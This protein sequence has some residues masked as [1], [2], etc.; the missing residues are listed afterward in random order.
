VFPWKRKRFKQRES[1]K[2]LFCHFYNHF[3]ATACHKAWTEGLSPV[4]LHC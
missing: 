4:L 1:L 2:Q 3:I